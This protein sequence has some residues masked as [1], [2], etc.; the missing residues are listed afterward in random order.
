MEFLI[1]S[2]EDASFVV[3]NKSG[4]KRFGVTNGFDFLPVYIFDE[5]N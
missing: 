4:V 2:G 3:S 1:I 5:N